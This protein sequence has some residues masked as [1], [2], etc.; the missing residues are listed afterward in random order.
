M[1]FILYGSGGDNGKSTLLSLMKKIFEDKYVALDE[2]LLFADKKKAVTPSQFGS[3]MGK[4]IATA[5]EPT[6]KY[7][8]G[9]V[10]KMLT[11]GDTV[12][13]KKCIVTPLHFIHKLK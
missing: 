6:N 10:I 7:I 11:G 9:E 13:G 8:H 3:L 5:I 2:D 4:T 1:F 12:Q